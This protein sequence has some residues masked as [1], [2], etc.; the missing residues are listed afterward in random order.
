[1]MKTL[2]SNI[3]TSKGVMSLILVMAL[4][5][6]VGKQMAKVTASD[7][8][9][10]IYSFKDSC[11]HLTLSFSIE[12][13]NGK[14]SASL[15]I[16]DSLVAEFVRGVCQPW[17]SEDGNEKIPER[18]YNRDDVQAFVDYYGHA[19]YER[20]LK[21]AMKDYEDRMSYLADDTT[22]TPEDRERIKNDVPMWAFDYAITKTIDAPA[23]VV[24]DA[25]AYCYYGGAHGGV[26]G[27]GAMTFDKSKGQ[28]M[29]HFLQD[30][31]TLDLQPYIR[32]G[33]IQYYKEY[34]DTLTDAQ[35][36]ERLQIEGNV[37]PLPQ[38]T[39]HFNAN[40][41]SLVFTYGQYEIAC[42]ADGMPSFAIPVKDILKY[43]TSE[44]ANLR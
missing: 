20:L 22:M 15:Q 12:L 14:D 19:A 1:M 4:C 40:A 16:C 35:L 17:Y 29:E 41:D 7:G 2:F 6:C 21:M 3:A 33:L 8:S 39:P 30:N 18:E 25:H 28:K 10:Q 23:F 31:V 42:Y 11:Q 34:G 13:P 32:K 9:T 37:I 44:A 27:A 24:Y 36:S 26:T 38:Q 43:L 5:S